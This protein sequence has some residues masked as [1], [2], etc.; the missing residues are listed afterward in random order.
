[1]FLCAKF[2]TQFF[3]EPTVFGPTNGGAQ[4]GVDA[5]CASALRQRDLL[6]RVIAPMLSGKWHELTVNELPNPG[7]H[8]YL[9]VLIPLP[10]AEAQRVVRVL[11]DAVELSLKF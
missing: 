2:V 6:Q 8:F 5:G 11:A 10:G 1:M 3:C 7:S 4:G 9:F